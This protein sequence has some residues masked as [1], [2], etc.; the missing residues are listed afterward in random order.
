MPH[1]AAPRRR[2]LVSQL[3]DCPLIHFQKMWTFLCL[4]WRRLGVWE[5]LVFLKLE[6]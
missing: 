1:A 4:L 6:V 3:G 2:K 5:G